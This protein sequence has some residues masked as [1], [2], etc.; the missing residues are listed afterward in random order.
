MFAE[1][2]PNG[3]SAGNSCGPQDYYCQYACE[4]YDQYGE[5]A[6]PCPEGGYYAAEAAECGPCVA[7]IFP[8][9]D[10]SLCE[11]PPAD[12]DQCST[13]VIAAQPV[14]RVR[15]TWVP[16]LS[17]MSIEQAQAALT[18]ARLTLG[19]ISF[20][21]T[22]AV[23]AGQVIRQDVPRDSCLPTNSAIDIVISTSGVTE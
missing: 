13:Q 20:E 1:C 21:R 16:D 11:P 4:L 3:G 17:G 19:E 15:I 22:T 10:F 2:T 5:C 7:E 12:R 9:F 23:A 6:P 8:G 14:G 18:Q